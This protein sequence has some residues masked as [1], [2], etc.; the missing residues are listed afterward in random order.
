MEC[1][2]CKKEM[3]KGYIYGERY[4]LKWLPADK[5]LYAGIYAIGAISLKSD[6]FWARQRAKAYRCSD[7]N[8]L[9]IDI[10]DTK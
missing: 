3:I 4:S 6:S 9:I 5:K 8:K 10:N 2:Y 7:C 1:P